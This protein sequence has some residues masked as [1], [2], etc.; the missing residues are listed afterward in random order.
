MYIYDVYH[1][2]ILCKCNYSVKLNSIDPCLNKVRIE[3]EDLIH[4]YLLTLKEDWPAPE[5]RPWRPRF[6]WG[7]LEPGC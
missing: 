5:S 2:E 4:I 3:N 6:C 1:K 7:K